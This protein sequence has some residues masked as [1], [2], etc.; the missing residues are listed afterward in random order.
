MACWGRQ[1]GKSTA[2]ALK[3]LHYAFS[4]PRSTVLIVSPSERQSRLLLEKVKA[5]LRSEVVLS[6]RKIGLYRSVARADRTGI[7]L[8]NGSKIIALPC[9][10]RAYKGLHGRPWWS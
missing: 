5:F 6:G 10:P 1:T 9:S 8:T 4:R 2:I 7:T 3:A